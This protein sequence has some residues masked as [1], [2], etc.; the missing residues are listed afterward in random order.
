MVFP[1]SDNELSNAR[2]TRH[3]NTIIERHTDERNVKM[4]LCESVK[5]VQSVLDVEAVA[6]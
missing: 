5:S 6:E 4:N 3:P 2:H 1:G